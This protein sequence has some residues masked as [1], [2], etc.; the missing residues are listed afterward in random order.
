MQNY[1]NV[2]AL[3]VRNSYGSKPDGW[4]N[5]HDDLPKRNVQHAH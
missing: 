1:K 5:I 3:P 4:D 2:K